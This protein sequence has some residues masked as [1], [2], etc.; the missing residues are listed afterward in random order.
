MTLNKS[1]SPIT[2]RSMT[3]GA[4]MAAIATLLGIIGIYIPVLSF[5]TGLFWAIPII[6]LIMRHDIRLGVMGVVVAGGLIS[7]LAGPVQAILLVVNLGG[8]AIAYGYCFKKNLSP[9]KA[10]LLG[11][12]ITAVS[13]AA[14]IVLSAFVANLPIS[15]WISEI[16]IAVDEAF[17]TYENMGIMERMLPEGISPEQYKQQIFQMI[18]TLLPGAYI[19][20]SMG[21]ALVN[22]LIARK[23]LRRLR[24]EIPD[25]PPFREWHFPWVIVWGIIGGLGCLL[26]GNHLGHRLL[27]LIGQ[28]ILYI[29]YP[30]LLISGISVVVFYWKSYRLTPP[31]K[32]LIIIG[33]IMFSHII[34][35][36]LLV[37]GL[38][39]PLFDY[40]RFIRTGAEQ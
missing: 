8:M 40:R 32:A 3:E 26:L 17:K 7:I 38:F 27:I 25:M 33:I 4:L 6:L 37:V 35:M 21:V 5:V 34:F 9:M 39:D 13:T 22:Y 36:L 29:Y 2:V 18:D 15:Q 24:Y 16:K 11:T 28:N 1:T 30:L 12:L 19:T 14:T 31:M 20:A 23:I 10:L